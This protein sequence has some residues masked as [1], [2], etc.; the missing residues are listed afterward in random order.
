MKKWMTLAFASMLALTLSLPGW[1][2]STTGN[3]STQTAAEK[4]ADADA[5]KDAK[6]KKK[7]SKK[8]TNKKAD[9]KQDATKTTGNKK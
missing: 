4:K 9:E 3:K 8:T 5:K 1:A 6:K 7:S 2:Q